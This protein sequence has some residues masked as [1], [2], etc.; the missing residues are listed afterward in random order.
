M[1]G[2]LYLLSLDW[3]LSE[4]DPVL[5]APCLVYVPQGCFSSSSSS[6]SPSLLP[7]KFSTFPNW[8]RDISWTHFL[9]TSQMGCFLLFIFWLSWVQ[10]LPPLGRVP[11]GQ[12]HKCASPS[13]HHLGHKHRK[14]WSFIYSLR[15]LGE[16]QH[17]N[18]RTSSI[19]QMLRSLA[20]L[21]GLLVTIFFSN[22]VRAPKGNPQAW[23]LQRNGELKGPIWVQV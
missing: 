16:C 17:G 12:Y 22:A 2:S 4:D 18:A 5:P 13:S 15:A 19:F 7:S 10:D 6:L 3:G 8:F 11:G 21:R 23:K 9:L 20:W 1:D 14:T